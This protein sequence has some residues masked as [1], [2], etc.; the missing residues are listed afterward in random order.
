MAITVVGSV[1]R[2]THIFPHLGWEVREILGGILY[3]VHALASLT[4]ETIIPVCNVGA[5]IFDNVI[6]FLRGFP[7]V[8]V[9]GVQRVER[10]NI[11][12]YILFASE[13]GTQYDEGHEVP[14]VFSQVRPFLNESQLI[15][16]SSMTGFDFELRTLQRI[17]QNAKCPVYFDYHILA[18]DRDPLGNR[19]VRRKRN[20][21]KWCASCDHLQLNQFE[22][23]LLGACSIESEADLLPLAE[24]ILDCGVTSIAVTLGARGALVCWSEGRN[25]QIEWFD[26]VKVSHSVDVT[27]CG[28]VFASAFIVH[29]LRTGELLKSYEFASKIAGLKC[30]FSG[31]NGL[32]DIADSS[33]SKRSGDEQTHCFGD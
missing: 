23:E 28:D 21:L 6:A 33:Y 19:F 11:H 16:A 2:G 31:L 10:D 26:A 14:I 15:F 24:S 12:C 7:N 27:G 13:Y 22:A 5:D 1:N 9:S 17:G 3:P 32:A 25:V 20:W 29:F 4:D 18:L 30:G 8:D